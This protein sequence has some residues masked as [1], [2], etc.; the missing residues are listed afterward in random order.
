M[1][2]VSARDGEHVDKLLRRFRKKVD[3]AGILKDARRH[4]YYLK[5]SVRKKQKQAA[6]AKRRKRSAVRAA[7]SR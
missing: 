1:T 2:F 4:E 3:A 5:P 6:A 7:R